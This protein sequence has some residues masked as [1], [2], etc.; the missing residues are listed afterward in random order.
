[1][2]LA[3]EYLTVQEVAKYLR[4]SPQTIRAM[5][6]GG[7]ITCVKCMSRW[8]IPR[9]GIELWESQNMRTVQNSKFENF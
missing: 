5:C 1:M 6:E 4:V 8:R 2:K 3:E 9:S 7:Q